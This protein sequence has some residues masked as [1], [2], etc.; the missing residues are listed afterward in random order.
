MP[1]L[2]VATSSATVTVATETAL[3]TNAANVLN[4]PANSKV[5][6]SGVVQCAAGTGGTAATVKVR[7]GSG[8]SGTQ[9]G[10]SVVSPAATAGVAAV[11]PFN[12]VDLTP[13]ANGQYTVTVTFTGNSSSVISSVMT[14]LVDAG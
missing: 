3:A 14:V 7:Q 1:Y 6:I 2:D 4:P 8:T 13:P 9:V 12:V 11:I 10:T 5:N